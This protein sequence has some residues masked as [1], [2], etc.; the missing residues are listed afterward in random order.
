MAWKKLDKPKFKLKIQPFFDQ[1]KIDMCP[2]CGKKQ[3][4]IKY[5]IR[6]LKGLLSF[7]RYTSCCDCGAEIS[8]G[9]IYISWLEFWDRGLNV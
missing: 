2:F 4:K 5:D 3:P 1:G 6:L 7:D 8:C 9:A